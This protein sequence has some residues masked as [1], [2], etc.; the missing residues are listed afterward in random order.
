MNST[1]AGA[2]LA[3]RHPRPDHQRRRGRRHAARHPH[4]RPQPRPPRLPARAQPDATG[5]RRR[6]PPSQPHHRPRRARR[7]SS[8]PRRLLRE[9]AARHHGSLLLPRHAHDRRHRRG[10]HHVARHAPPRRGKQRR[11]PASA[12]QRGSRE[13]NR[14]TLADQEATPSSPAGGLRSP[15]ASSS[16]TAA[17]RTESPH[18]GERWDAFLISGMRHPSGY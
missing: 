3:A 8:R 12:G 9:A 13:I 5:R 18:S 17:S 15:A 10:V 2:A 14:M 11:Y 1:R 7:R 16:G 6:L 4:P